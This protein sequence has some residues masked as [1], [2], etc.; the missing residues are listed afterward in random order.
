MKKMKKTIYTLIAM[1]GF[2]NFTMAQVPYY[3]PTNNLVGWYPF[4]GNSNDE[5]GAGNNLNNNGAVLIMNR[6]NANNSAY[7]FGSNKSLGKS[8]SNTNGQNFTWSFW[9]KNNT[10]NSNIY[11]SEAN[12]QS[13]SGGGFS[14]GSNNAPY[15]IPQFICQGIATNVTNSSY[16]I[17]YSEWYHYV[18]T[19]SN[20]DFKIFIN[21]QQNSSGSNTYLSYNSSTELL[22][23]TNNNGDAE[24][25]DIGMWNRILTPSEIT[26]LYT[27][28]DCSDFI[29]KQP[30]NQTV[31][32][33]S[34]ASFIVATTDSLATYQWQTDLGMGFQNIS[35]AGQF[36]GATND[37]LIVS[38]TSMTNDNQNFRCI[39]SSGTCKDTSTTAK[40]TV[41]NSTGINSP[42]NVNALKVYPNPAS[43]SLHIDL[44]KPGYY[45]AKLS[46]VAGQSIISPTT[47]TVDISALA[48][49][50]YILTIYDSNNQL[51]STNKVGIV[52]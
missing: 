25:D 46:S 16:V 19:K 40:L 39:V 5:S 27:A 9:V 18:I 2:A 12:R 51:I 45:T 47:G 28:V 1:I 13:T 14:F 21:G 4:N 11:I 32:I 10:S 33:N 52:K 15:N 31:N 30:T 6:F 41:N 37:T 49:G 42:S 7:H 26:A 17:N 23:N 36:N 24:L 35:S 50:V 43:T 3:V 29:S 38:N 34:N 44:V 8:T 20:S 48:N 22:I